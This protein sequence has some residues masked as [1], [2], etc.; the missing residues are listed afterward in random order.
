MIAYVILF[1]QDLLAGTL[2]TLT[3]YSQRF[4]KTTLQGYTSLQLDGCPKV[5]KKSV[6]ADLSTFHS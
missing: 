3:R 4:F 6:I 5:P 1:Q 2:V